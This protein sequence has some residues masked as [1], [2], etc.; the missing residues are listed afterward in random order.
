MRIQGKILLTLGKE[1]CQDGQKKSGK[2]L[3]LV[4]MLYTFI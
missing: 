3:G 4:R 1:C 2:F